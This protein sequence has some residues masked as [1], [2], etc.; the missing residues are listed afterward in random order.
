MTS[1]ISLLAAGGSWRWQLRDSK[2][3]WVEMGSEVKWLSQGVMR[4]GRVTGSPSPGVATVQDDDGNEHNLSA[5][6]LTAV[7]PDASTSGPK[8]AGRRRLRGLVQR[9]T[10][11]AQIEF[12]QTPAMEEAMHDMADIITTDVAPENQDDAFEATSDVIVGKIA[13]RLPKAQQALATVKAL[14]ER[15]T[16]AQIRL[17]V[18]IQTRS[19][20]DKLVGKATFWAQEFL[21]DM[22]GTDNPTPSWGA[23]PTLIG[24]PNPYSHPAEFLVESSKMISQ[25]L[26]ALRPLVSAGD[27]WR[28]Q[29]RDKKG[30]GS[31]WV[32]MSDGWTRA[33]TGTA[34]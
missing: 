9:K 28:W 27:S 8:A 22:G 26:K 1:T 23:I 13:E 6:R 7:T 32:Q 16:D 34:W 21:G 18:Y 29:L 20:L 31:D 12:K 33:S 5:N 15:G 24:L 17:A 30:S 10:R 19:R 14:K 4:S 3:Q 25:L 2:G 11:K